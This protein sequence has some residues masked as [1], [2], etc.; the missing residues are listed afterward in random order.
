[1]P[2][3]LRREELQGEGNEPVA[4]DQRVLRLGGSREDLFDQGPN[5]MAKGIS[6]QGFRASRNTA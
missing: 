2:A 4:S 1:M 3:L 6:R 5:T